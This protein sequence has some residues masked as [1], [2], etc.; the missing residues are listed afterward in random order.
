MPVPQ[1]TG[2]VG[3]KLV[4]RYTNVNGI[5]SK[6]EEVKKWME[7]GKADV[8]ALVETM[9]DTATVDCSFCDLLRL[10]RLGCRKESGGGVAL[11]VKKDIQIIRMYELEVAGLEVL[12]VKVIALRMNLLLG[13]IYAPVY[14][15][16]VFSKL[17]TSM[18]RIPP[19][20]RRNIVL[21][22]VFNCPKLNW[23]RDAGGASEKER[24]LLSLQKEFRLW[25]KVKEC[26]RQRGS[27]SSSLD[28][29]FS[30]QV[31]LVRGVRIIKPPAATWLTTMAYDSAS[32]P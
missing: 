10:N 23:S 26:T 31:S 20:L 14:D 7:E 9:A 12:W 27:S 8:V 32:R 24:D 29:V 4:V 3:R 18:E 30:S 19:Y 6:I 15:D 21:V 11:A 5:R 2:E 1:P 17:R 25:Q 16:D 28:L 13:A 22:R